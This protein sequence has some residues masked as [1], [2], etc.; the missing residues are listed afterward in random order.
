MFHPVSDGKEETAIYGEYYGLS[1]MLYANQSE[2]LYA[3]SR[4]AG[5]RVAVHDSFEYPIVNA[6]GIRLSPGDVTS[7][8]MGLTE[9]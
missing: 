5:F 9:V 2:Y 8:A 3:Q 6:R 7:I 1:V 4:G